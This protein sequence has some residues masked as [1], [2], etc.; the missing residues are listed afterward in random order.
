MGVVFGIVCIAWSLDSM[1][2]SVSELWKIGFGTV[3][4]NNL[5]NKSTSLIGGVLLASSPQ[6]ALSYL[7]LAFNALYTNMFIAQ[8]WSSYLH[9]RKTLRV[10][11]P[12]GQQRASYWLSVPFRYAIPMT[13]VSG[14]FHWLASQSLFMVQ[15][16]VTQVL[17]REIVPTQQISTCGYS[18][19]AIILTTVTATFIALGG[20]VV[21]KF[22]YP[23]GMPMAGSCSMA[24]S[25]A[26]HPPLGDVDA[27]LKPVQWG[28]VS[29]EEQTDHEEEIVRHCSFSSL[30]VEM[31]LA[32]HLYA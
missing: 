14:L 22:E 16:T 32:G 23:A 3:A 27:H 31:P 12:T 2:S 10:T 4:G 20:I 1:P 6:V 8:E 28:V 24:I 17:T 26:C 9:N 5:L 19:F 29:H 11:C 13:V 30:P 21:G 7:N 25:A 15:I 18:P